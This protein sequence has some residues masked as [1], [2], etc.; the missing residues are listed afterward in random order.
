VSCVPSAGGLHGGSISMSTFQGSEALLGL[1]GVLG[2]KG[3]KLRYGYK[4]HYLAAVGT[5]LV[6]V[7]YPT[8]ASVRDGLCSLLS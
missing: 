7:V 6:L 5:G 1:V 8:A 2:K 3:C 4:H